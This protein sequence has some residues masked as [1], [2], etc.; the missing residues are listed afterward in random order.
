MRNN[1]KYLLIGAASLL[2]IPLIAM[3]F[4]EEVAWDLLDF[5]VAGILLT[6]AALAY[7]FAARLLPKYRVVSG[8][9]VAVVLAL[10]WVELAVGL[11]GTPLAG[12]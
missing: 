2:L 9:V 8:V 7:I 6:G 12:S 1:E 11:F 5:I 3:Q 10:V 4:T